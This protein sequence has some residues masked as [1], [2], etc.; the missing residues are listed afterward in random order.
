MASIKQ[1]L[2]D[3]G[4]NFKALTD[5]MNGE[6]TPQDIKDYLK[7]QFN[8]T[9]MMYA[10]RDNHRHYLFLRFL[11]ELVKDEQKT[12]GVYMDIGNFI[13]GKLPRL[14]TLFTDIFVIDNYVYIQTPRPGLWIG[15][16]GETI[17]AI[18]REIN[19]GEKYDYEIKLLEDNTS[20]L[21][22][23]IRWASFYA[24]NY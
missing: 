13:Q 24:N 20:P 17:D 18:T 14:A 11:A 22:Q 19:H 1:I 4:D 16:C 9:Q 2:N 8:S 6:V 12:E 10:L 15:K 5:A 7:S 21:Y 3:N 23:I